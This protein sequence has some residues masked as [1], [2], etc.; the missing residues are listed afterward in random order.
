[1]TVEIRQ[2]GPQDVVAV[3][4]AEVDYTNAAEVRE[5]LLRTLNGTPR[6]LTIDMSATTF[7]DVAGVRAIERVYQRA[8]ACGTRLCL[9]APMPGVLRILKLTGIHRIIPIAPR[10]A[11]DGFPLTTR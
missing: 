11:D 7:C 3:M 5:V 10:L 4:P 2:A 6:T 1:M 9:R 8:R